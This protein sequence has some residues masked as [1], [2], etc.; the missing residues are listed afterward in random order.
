MGI[1]HRA[2]VIGIW[3]LGISFVLLRSVPLCLCASNFLD[4]TVFF[5]ARGRLLRAAAGGLHDDPARASIGP[6][7]AS[8]ALPANSSQ[9]A[10]SRTLICL[11]GSDAAAVVIQEIALAGTACALAS[12]YFPPSR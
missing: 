10:Q 12:Q 9:T 4:S 7:A 11:P 3:S 5:T 6:S 2:L 1:F 8:A